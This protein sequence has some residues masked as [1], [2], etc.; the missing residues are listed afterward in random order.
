MTMKYVGVRWGNIWLNYWYDYYLALIL[1]PQFDFVHFSKLSFLSICSVIV[2]RSWG[3]QSYD[4]ISKTICYQALLNCNLSKYLLGHQR[5]VLFNKKQAFVVV[6][7]ALQFP[8][9]FNLCF[10]LKNERYSQ[11]C[12]WVVF[13]SSLKMLGEKTPE[14]CEHLV[15]QSNSSIWYEPT[16]TL[17]FN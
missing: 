1:L 6:S 7:L 8:G 16:H 2:G 14:R 15:S 12:P 9:F 4:L 11:L 13:C 17:W 5:L 3:G 10:L